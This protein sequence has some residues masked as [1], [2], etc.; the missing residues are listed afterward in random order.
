GERTRRAL[1]DL[2]RPVQILV[3]TAGQP[4]F[5]ELYDVVREQVGRFQAASPRISVETLDPALDPGRVAALAAEY[6]LT[7]EEVAGGGAVIFRSGARR[8]AVALLDMATFAPGEVGGKLASFRGED[9]FASALLEVSHPQQREV[10]FPS[11]HGE[12][13]ID[14]SDDGSDRARVAR[15]L[16][17]TGLRP[18][19]LPAVTPVPAGCA[20]LA[21]FG[22][23][24]P[25]APAE[26][27]ALDDW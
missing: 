17:A 4:E 14:A 2:D 7:S 6:A 16:G 12:L 26:A 3:I 19:E 8:R 10:C 11:G 9:A 23:K 20:A 21:I 1:A 24:R 18:R 5:A 15:A 22:P 25:F 27:R 13:G